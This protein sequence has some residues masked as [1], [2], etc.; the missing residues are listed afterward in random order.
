MFK[1]FRTDEFE[2]CMGKLL[3]NEQQQRVDGI[4]EEIKEKGVTGDPLGLPFLREKRID[5]K[6]V[7]FLVYTDLNAALMVSVSN[8]KA[9][10]QTIDTIK[11]YLTEFRRLIESL[12]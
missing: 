2:R 8:K 4:E 7:Y 6:R 5:D 10:Q 3:T 12:T 9:Q 11:A 1:V